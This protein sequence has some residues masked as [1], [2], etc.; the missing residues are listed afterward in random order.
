MFSFVPITGVPATNRASLETSRASLLQGAGAE[1]MVPLSPY[2]YVEVFMC[3]YN[4]YI[5]AC[6]LPYIYIYIYM[7]IYGSASYKGGTLEYPGAKYHVFSLSTP[8]ASILILSYMSIL[9]L[10]SV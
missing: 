10:Y 7:Y 5:H 8:Y 9:T 6:I 3:I 4:I 2:M 1:A